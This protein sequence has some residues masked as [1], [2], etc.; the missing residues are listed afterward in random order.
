MLFRQKQLENYREKIGSSTPPPE[1]PERNF[2][3]WTSMLK[4][5]IETVESLDPKEFD[6]MV[7]YYKNIF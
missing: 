1:P 7:N 2:L 4:R 5:T 3:V 6:I